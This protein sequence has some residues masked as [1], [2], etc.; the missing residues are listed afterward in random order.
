MIKPRGGMAEAASYKCEST[1]KHDPWL[2]WQMKVYPNV[3]FLQRKHYWLLTRPSTGNSTCQG[4]FS[5]GEKLF[6]PLIIGILADCETWEQTDAFAV[7]PSMVY[8][9]ILRNFASFPGRLRHV[10]D[11]FLSWQWCIQAYPDMSCFCC[12]AFSYLMSLSTSL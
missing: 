10:L 2:V 12:K 5:A 3:C 4:S 8:F 9:L 6:F 1:R 7:T 11:G